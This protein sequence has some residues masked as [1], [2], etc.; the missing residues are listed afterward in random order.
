MTARVT[1]GQA[2]SPILGDTENGSA[3]SRMRSVRGK[4]QIPRGAGSAS[5]MPDRVMRE[6][7]P[8]ED[9]HP[10][11]MREIVPRAEALVQMPGNVPGPVN[12]HDRDVAIDCGWVR[13]L[14]DPRPKTPGT[15]VGSLAASSRCVQRRGPTEAGMGK[16][17]R[18]CQVLHP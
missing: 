16:R 10:S 11:G 2:P 12:K 7:C 6:E 1:N 18:S 14:D 8:G 5:G 17:R 13:L 3:V 15:P 4:G 9:S